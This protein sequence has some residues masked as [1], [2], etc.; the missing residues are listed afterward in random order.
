MSSLSQSLHEAWLLRQPISIQFLLSTMCAIAR[1]IASHRWCLRPTDRASMANKA[2]MKARQSVPCRSTW[3]E[4]AQQPWSWQLP[5]IARRAMDASYSSFL[6][7]YSS[8][9]SGTTV[10]LQLRGQ[11]GPE[12][13]GLP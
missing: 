5:S 3:T 1:I 13:S 11:R 8:I 7:Y 6:F 4:S 10:T 12:G 9:P 2:G